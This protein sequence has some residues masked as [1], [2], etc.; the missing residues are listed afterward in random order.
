M[1]KLARCAAT[2]IAM[3]AVSLSAAP[4]VAVPR[5][6]PP[7]PVTAAS[8][9]PIPNSY[10]VT[11]KAGTDAAAFVSKVPLLRKAAF[12]Y[13][14]VFS[15]FSAT[16]TE[17]Q[18]DFVRRSP[19]ATGVEQNAQATL[20]EEGGRALVPTELWGLDRIDQ[21]QLPL[22]QRFTTSGN[23][24]GVRAYVLDTGIDYR[25]QEFGGRAAF[26]FDAM[27]DGRR[28]ADCQGHG[29]HVA[30]TVGGRTYGVARKASLVSVRVLGCDG[31]GDWAGIIAGIDWVAKNAVRPA[32]A[33]I[34][35]GGERSEAVNAATDA[36]YATGVLPVV[37]AGNS[38]VD[39]CDVSP[40]SATGA[41][42]VGA[43]NADDEETHFSNWGRCLSVYAP[44]QNILSAKLGGGSVA[45]DGTSMAAP[46]VTGVASLF[47]AANPKAS[48]A[49]VAAWI[50]DGSTK[51]VV[52][53]IGPSS[54]N[55]LLF[56]NKA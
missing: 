40:A 5:E 46:H 44:G 20:Y 14:S 24:A 33:N 52:T 51:D 17:A 6:R 8:G 22:D 21:R 31:K 23:G 10:I 34:S 50:R 55:R 42:T 36:L 26:G 56:T 3:A 35:L 49:D 29:T 12:T 41:L 4:G 25:H 2:V 32:V 27:G 1:R 43:T 48:S 37:A 54:P 53:S 39:A 38:A 16:L 18:L 11:L 15:G 45:H 47:L 9:V 28:G 30:G 13:G 7:I 19:L